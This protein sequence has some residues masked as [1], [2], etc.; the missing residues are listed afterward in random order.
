MVTNLEKALKSDYAE[1]LKQ[2][3]ELEKEKKLVEKKIAALDNTYSEVLAI[4]SA[5]TKS[6]AKG[7]PRAKRG[8]TQVLIAEML[9][10][11]KKPLRANEIIQE[12]KKSG[13][14][15]S[16]ASVR[17]QLPKMVQAKKITKNNRDKSYNL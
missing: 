9:R 6:P 17:Q 8:Q 16:D 12:I 1:Y 14:I 15:V 4:M 7:K 5:R 3:K 10:K 11:A 13:G 2:L